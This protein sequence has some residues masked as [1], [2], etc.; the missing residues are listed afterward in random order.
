MRYVKEKRTGVVGYIKGNM[1]WTVGYGHG[2]VVEDEYT[3]ATPEEI[4]RFKKEKKE[5]EQKLQALHDKEAKL[6]ARAGLKHEDFVR[7]RGCYIEGDKL[8]VETRENGVNER[9]VE[10]IRNPNYITSYP[11]DGDPTYEYYEFRIPQKNHQEGLVRLPDGSG[12]ALG[13]LPLPDDHW[14]YEE[15]VDEP[16][17]PFRM[18]TSDPRRKEWEKKIR[19]AARYA[20]RA[21]TMNGRESDFDPDALVQNMIIGMLGYHT[22]DGLALD[23]EEP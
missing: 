5:H 9:S 10:A 19:A 18:G 12:V 15:G 23:K 21:A 2:P 4:E 22:P 14:L 3:P 8:I 13:S 7:F 16:P 20:V 1:F 17:M 11:D 6:L